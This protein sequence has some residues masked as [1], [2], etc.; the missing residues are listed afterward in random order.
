MIGT[1]GLKAVSTKD[2]KQLLLL[3]HRGDLECPITQI[4]L[5]TSGLLRLGDDLAVLGG[6]DEKGVRA[7]LVSVLAERS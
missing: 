5:A 3:L 6:V 7:V 2:L 4:G 1:G